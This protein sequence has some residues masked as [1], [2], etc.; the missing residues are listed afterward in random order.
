VR[1]RAA[2]K[3]NLACLPTKHHPKAHD[4]LMSPRASFSLPAS[5]AAT[6]GL[7]PSWPPSRE[8]PLASKCPQEVAVI[9]RVASEPSPRGLRH[10]DLIFVVWI[11][12]ARKPVSH[13]GTIRRKEPKL[14]SFHASSACDLS[15][16]DVEHLQRSQFSIALSMLLPSEQHPHH[17][18]QKSEMPELGGALFRQPP[19]PEVKRFGCS[20]L[21]WK[22]PN[23]RC[24][25]ASVARKSLS[26]TRS[27]V[28]LFDF[29]L[30]SGS[31]EVRKR[32]SPLP[33][34][35][36]LDA[37][38]RGGNLSSFASSHGEMKTCGLASFRFIDGDKPQTVAGRRPTGEPTPL[39]S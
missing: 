34:G 2:G 21:S 36:L 11:T 18:G 25:A 8:L 17:R 10:V 15:G 14:S 33:P 28:M 29:L 5:V 39:R 35:K 26:P 12:V 13:A 20:R 24:N 31:S 3:S 7:R 22:N 30:L 1:R 37:I 4:G 6:R 16:F 19:G 27:I 38:R 9:D 32:L 23:V